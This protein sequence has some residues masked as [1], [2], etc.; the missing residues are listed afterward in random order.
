MTLPHIVQAKYDKDFRIRLGFNDGIEASVDF[1][2]WLDGP[3][4][5]PLR[6]LSYFRKFFLDLTPA[7]QPS[8]AGSSRLELER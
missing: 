8:A 6:T 4:F 5:E 2:P 3:I 1:S 7:L